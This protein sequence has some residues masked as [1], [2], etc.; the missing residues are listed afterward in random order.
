MVIV[1]ILL[2]III[3]S[4]FFVIKTL[5]EMIETFINYKIVIKTVAETDEDFYDNVIKLLDDNNGAIE[6]DN[7]YIKRIG[8]NDD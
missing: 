3:I 2:C 4:I 7:F 6:T 8:D 5:N 1:E